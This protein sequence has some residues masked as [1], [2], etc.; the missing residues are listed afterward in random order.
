MRRG[1]VRTRQ[2]GMAWGYYYWREGLG[3]S[4]KGIW[5]RFQEP[6]KWVRAILAIQMYFMVI[7]ILHEH[8]STIWLASWELQG[9]LCGSFNLETV[10]GAR[11]L[12]LNDQGQS[13]V[14]RILWGTESRGYR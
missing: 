5:E 10:L 13:W 6:K 7:S 1:Q 3:V 12:K 8:S 2:I 14:C 9:Y 4:S 11:K